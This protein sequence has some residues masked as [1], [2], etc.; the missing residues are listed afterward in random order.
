M[1][2]P[3]KTIYVDMDD[4]LCQAACHFLIIVE[5]EF[6]K[7]ISYEQLTNF[8]VGHACGLS[9]GERAELYR[10]V[11]RPEELM[12]MAPIAEAGTEL[13]GWKDRGFEIAV[14]TGR[15]PE[16]AEVSI[17]WLAKHKIAHSS[18]TV[19][20]KYARFPTEKTEAISLAELATRR[21]CWAVE[22]SL[23]MARFLAGSMKVPV[24][25]IDRPWN[26]S[27]KDDIRINRYNGWGELAAALP[28]NG[29][30]IGGRE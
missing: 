2:I 19:V 28:G 30:S 20:D 8:D 3:C 29:I 11:H 4:V 23:P 16:S 27:D 1:E 9:S 6:G 17:A 12:R 14:V 13:K 7:R 15:P 18:F 10:I 24:A 22:D 21:F 5:R 26:R 25:L